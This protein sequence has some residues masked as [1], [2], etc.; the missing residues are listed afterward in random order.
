LIYK[1]KGQSKD[2]V[3]KFNKIKMTLKV[4]PVSD[5]YI[6]A[7]PESF[8]NELDWYEDTEVDITLNDNGLY[9]EESE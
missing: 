4:D 5:E 2:T 7:V 8:V 1:I 9:I 3:K 6:I